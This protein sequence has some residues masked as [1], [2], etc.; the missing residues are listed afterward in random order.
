MNYRISGILEAVGCLR[1]AFA[2]S[3][4]PVPSSLSRLF[5]PHYHHALSSHHPV[6]IYIPSLALPSSHSLWLIPHSLSRL[7]A[8]RTCHPVR[9]LVLCIFYIPYPRSPTPTP[10]HTPHPLHSSTHTI[11]PQAEPLLRRVTTLHHIPRSLE[12]P[13]TDSQETP[14]LI[15]PLATRADIRLPLTVYPNPTITPCPHTT[16][17]HPPNQGKSMEYLS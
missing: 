13:R 1:Q 2:G 6:L 8:Y 9:G 12:F 3:H 4:P 5:A 15:H 17:S 11:L 7:W 14:K 10:H 16:H